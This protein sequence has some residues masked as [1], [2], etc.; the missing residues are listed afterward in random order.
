MTRGLQLTASGTRRRGQSR[1]QRLLK[2]R[3]SG[4]KSKG[5]QSP[6]GRT[7][8]MRADLAQR[9]RGSVG[10]TDTRPL[11]ELA[12]GPPHGA[13]PRPRAPACFIQQPQ[14]PASFLSAVQRQQDLGSRGQWSD[15]APPAVCRKPPAAFLLPAIQVPPSRAGGRRRRAD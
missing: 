11:R 8:M 4:W 6:T 3:A 2:P 1:R 14:A 15:R 9:R 13:R 7:R 12:L 10:R 5:Q